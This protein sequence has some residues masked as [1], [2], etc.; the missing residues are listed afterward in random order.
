MQRLVLSKQPGHGLF[1]TVKSSENSAR[2]SNPAPQKSSDK[3]SG[4]DILASQELEFLKKHCSMLEKKC[5]ELTIQAAT[6]SS[7]R[8][9]VESEKESVKRSLDILIREK[10]QALSSVEI[11]SQQ[12]K[13]QTMEIDELNAEV[14]TIPP[15]RREIRELHFALN[16]EGK[17]F[18]VL[19]KNESEWKAEVANL[20]EEIAILQ[21]KLSE[22]RRECE[23]LRNG[24]RP[25]SLAGSVMG[26]ARSHISTIDRVVPKQQQ[27]RFDS[28]A[29]V[30]PSSRVALQK[31]RRPPSIEEEE[32]EFVRS[33]K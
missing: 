6:D 23:N 9:R 26:S 4:S 16:E 21:N 5:S 7:M 28:Q 10:E 29:I 22:S 25:V 24:S 15:L 11:L 3:P 2:P 12:V 20:V 17:K 8:K 33:L 27:S 14:R 30:Q 32:V 18:I 13:E 1:M 31:S 19:E